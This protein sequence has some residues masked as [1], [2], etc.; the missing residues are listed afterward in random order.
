MACPYAKK[1]RGTIAFCTLLNRKVSTLRYPCK[2]NYRRCPIYIR[3]Q[4][5]AAAPQGPAPEPAPPAPQTAPTAPPAQ[6]APAPAEEK[7][8]TGPGGGVVRPSK[9]LCDS[10]ILA[11]LITSGVAV[12]RFRGSLA[13]LIEALQD[14]TR[15][16]DKLL[17]FVGQ[18]GDVSVRM[19]AHKGNVVY[20]FEKELSPICGNEASSLLEQRRNETVDGII[21]E[22]KWE[23]IPLWKETIQSELA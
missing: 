9:S 17:F 19:L 1:I 5:R 11:A 20:A 4:A 8:P 10:L 3:Y 21:Y 2:G 15:G 18:T 7:A 14:K 16:N 22:I 13:S 12:D 23:D 6:P